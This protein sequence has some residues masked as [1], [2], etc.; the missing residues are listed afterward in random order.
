MVAEGIA[1]EEELNAARA[2]LEEFTNDPGTVIGAPRVFQLWS[3]RET[4]AY[5]MRV[6]VS[7]D[8]V[9]ET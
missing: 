4:A 2:S 7:S 5:G 1:S 3:R 9:S 8:S 6:S